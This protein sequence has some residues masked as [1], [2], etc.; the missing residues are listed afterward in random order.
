MEDVLV[1]VDP[2]VADK[3]INQSESVLEC[4]WHFFPTVNGLA[5]SPAK[6]QRLVLPPASIALNFRIKF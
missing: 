6:R 2:F 3:H 5:R 1:A 4:S